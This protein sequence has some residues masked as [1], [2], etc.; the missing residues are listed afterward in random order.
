VL[1]RIW[2][3]CRRFKGPYRNTLGVE[4]T[5]LA[6]P[7]TGSSPSWIAPRDTTTRG[8]RTERSPDRWHWQPPAGFPLFWEMCCAAAAM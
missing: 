6:V 7:S 4:Q 2:R 1:W 5:K 8:A 3:A